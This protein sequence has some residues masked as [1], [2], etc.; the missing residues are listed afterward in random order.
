MAGGGSSG[1]G[2]QTVTQTQQIPEWEQG[3][4]QQNQDI[5]ASLASRPYQPY[6]GQLVAGLTPQQ[7]QGLDQTSQA[8]TSY[9]PDLNA[10]KALTANSAQPWTAQTAQQYMSP[11]AMAAMQPQMQALQLQ[12]AQ[13]QHQIDANS[14]QAGAFGDARQ[15][16]ATSLNNFYGN[17]AQNDLVGQG[18]NSAY[19]SGMAAFQQGQQQQLAAGQQ[20]GNL[21]GA[22]QQLGLTGADANFNAGTQQ[23]QL[24]QTQLN[25]AYQNFMQ[26]QQYPLQALN[27]RIA[28]LANSP[29]DTTQTL[30]QPPA[31]AT[32]MNV[33]A[34]GALAGGVGSLLNGGNSSGGGT[35]TNI[36]GS[37]IRIKKDIEHIGETDAGIPIYSFSYI[38][39]N[40]K[41]VGVMA[42]DVEQVIPEAVVINSMGIKMVNYDLV[43]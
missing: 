19:N 14:T 15:G 41:R 38:W 2:S 21:A 7:Q 36:F 10:A 28:A 1:G 13:Q 22:Q 23:Q 39:E 4:A 26:Q 16:V 35:T 20:F 40:K 25:L 12:Q 34:F 18:M 17:L 30:V 43:R 27:E 8:A 11:Y 33:G 6:Q 9:Q 3:Y 37:D 31:S 24:N 29:Y 42:Q 5:A 32:A